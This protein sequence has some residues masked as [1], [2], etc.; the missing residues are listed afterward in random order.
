MAIRLVLGLGMCRFG[1]VSQASQRLS[2]RARRV[3]NELRARRERL[4]LTLDQAAERS[5]LS[6]ATISRTENGEGVR[7]ANVAALL[8]AY[9]VGVAE[10]QRFVALAKKAKERGWWTSADE[11][12]M[13]ASYQYLAELEQEASWI[14]SFSPL[15][16]P[17]LLQTEQ[18]A[19]QTIA[20]T[21]AERLNPQQQ[22]E[23]VQV[24][25]K[26]QERL[27]Q[28]EYVTI[29][30]EEVLLRL[31]GLPSLKDEQL[32]K[33]LD[34]AAEGHCELQILPIKVGIHPGITGGFSVLGGFEPADTVVAYYDTPNGDAS[35]EGEAGRA[36]LQRE[37]KQLREV[38][39]DSDN[40]LKL[41]SKLKES[42]L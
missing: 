29:L 15:V 20:T 6:P 3:V 41:I 35:F 23:L 1:H 11:A 36:P 19:H 24:R 38:A 18:Y 17:G 8:T 4:G 9:G 39:L 13:S 27:G 10:I 26:R 28:F 16:I 14:H 12:V 7:P 34:I 5:S 21:W 25:M 42:S 22:T 32:Q 37:F 30:L 33:L 40:S 31:A 2:L